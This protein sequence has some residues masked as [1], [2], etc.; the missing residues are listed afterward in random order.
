MVSGAGSWTNLISVNIYGAEL[1]NRAGLFR[2]G[3]ACHD[4]PDVEQKF[5]PAIVIS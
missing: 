3:S 2:I 4:D 1:V 5:P